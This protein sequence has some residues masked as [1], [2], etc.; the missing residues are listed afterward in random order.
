MEPESSDI[1]MTTP[2]T[3]TV[4]ST[5]RDAADNLKRVLSGKLKAS[6]KRVVT[7]Q[8]AARPHY[9][10]VLTPVQAETAYELPPLPAQVPVRRPPIDIPSTTDIAMV[11]NVRDLLQTVSPML[12]PTFKFKV[13][14][15]AAEFNFKLLQ[16]HDFQL[17]KLLNI[18]TNSV[19]AYGS[20]FKNVN[21]IEG[22]LGRHHRWLALQTRLQQ[23][24]EFPLTDLPEEVKQHDLAAALVRGNH[25]SADKNLPFLAKALQAEVEKGWALILREQDAKLVPRLLIAP[26]GVAEQV[27]VSATGEFVAKLRVTHDLSF[28]GEFSNES[29]NS[30]VDKTQLEPCMFGHTLVR[31]IHRIVHYRLRHPNK[32]IWLRKEDFKSAYRRLHINAATATTS[33]VAIEISGDKYIL[34]PLRLPF[35][36]APCPADFCVVSDIIT[37][38]INDLMRNPAWDPLLVHSAYVSNIP[39]AKI[40]PSNIPFAAGRELSVQ[41]PDNDDASADCF[42]DDI[43]TAAVDVNDNLQ[44]IT[45]APCTIIHALAHSAETTTYI[46]RQNMIADDKNEAEGGPEELKICLGWLL[47]TRRL[48]VLL[49]VHKFHAWLAQT[50]A[51]MNQKTANNDQLSSLL[52]RLEHV[53]IVIPM[54]AHFLNNLRNLQI[55][56]ENSKHNVRISTRVREDLLLSTA[57]LKQAHKGISMNLITFRSPD[58]IYINDASEHGLGGFATH[59]RAWRWCIPSILQGRAHINLLEFLA[60]LISIWIDILEGV[61]KPQDCLLGMG[62]S[63]AAMGWLRRSNFR[64]SHE[65]N[66][67]WLVKQDVA[68]KV[69]SL[70]LHAEAV[71]Y[72][73]WF[74]G[75]DNVVADSLSR[76]C[77]FLSPQAHERFLSHT[78]PSQLPQA[79]RIL[80]VPDEISSFV[81]SI[82]ER[83]P[84]QQLRCKPQKPSD[85]A[86]SEIGALSSIASTWKRPSTSTNFPNFSETSSWPPSPKPSEKHPSLQA[87]ERIWWREQSMPPSHMWHRPSGQT[88][89]RTPDWT[90]TV[91]LA[92]LSTNSCEPTEIKMDLE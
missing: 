48:L 56:A 9:K 38:T 4:P 26:L 62:D 25:K 73:Q 14:Q 37:D 32:I 28:P 20:E 79:F 92:S 82:L 78:V 1:I 51:V 15:D 60:Q 35:G 57:F 41:L 21:Q 86:R 52:G 74:K 43:I 7:V 39:A 8:T 40:C 34:I 47:D 67:E 55:T 68:R 76:D 84:V 33:A 63:T 61:T 49:P 19:T 27:G 42:I 59:G 31:V 90:Q 3:A 44:R 88:T 58:K 72:R 75:E 29:V 10:K 89:G 70:V 12:P 65:D 69:A 85:L 54:F 46:R 81:S 6:S 36:G 5:T 87:I 80:P 30:R 24:A 83:L 18:P 77:Y 66:T 91:R 50:E 53:A 16:Y 2:Q 22:L 17:D 13:T 64:E 45:A 23:G 11:E 71:L